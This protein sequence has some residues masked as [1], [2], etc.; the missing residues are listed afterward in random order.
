[1]TPTRREFLEGSASASAA[2]A[3]GGR[4]E[5]EGVRADLARYVGF[6]NKASGGAGDEATGGWLE[7]EL[8]RAGY[9]VER[10]P[11]EAPAFAIQ[12]ARI[13]C[14][15][16]AADVIPQ[17]IVVPTG[18]QGVSGP[19][20]HYRAGDPP[21]QPLDGAIAFVELP[22][23]RW[24]TSTAPAIRNA[25]REAA[26]LGARALVLVTNGPTGDALALNADPRASLAPIPIAI[27][28]PRDSAALV[29]A[30]ASGAAATLYLTG[31]V[32]HRPAF[33][34][35]GRLRR[36]SGRW[37]VISTPRSGWFTCAGERG[38]G[39]AAWLSLARWAPGALKHHSLMLLANS[40]HEYEYLGSE[41]AIAKMAPPPA[42]TAF[43][44][45]LGA[46]VAARDWHELGGGRLAPLPSADPQRFLVTS[47]PLLPTARGA[48]AGLPGLE[49]PY[50]A[51]KGGQGEA[52]SILAAG[53]ENVAGI[54]GN[55]RF[56]HSANDDARCLEDRL[57]PPV[58][59]ACRTLL[60]SIR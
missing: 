15:S 24:S 5:T 50:A 10:Q 37:I 23:A 47:D 39:V 31:T 58:I 56:H 51:S 35:I 8:R 3:M 30:S 43:W 6:G 7:D 25:A 53:Y 45:H 36:P 44:L 2:V 33:N 19:L 46:N 41:H 26:E 42:E 49:M 38:P 16:A 11:F 14:G 28:A 29:K 22:S 4:V 20:R 54:F 40:G 55:H 13:E 48:F 1:M 21:G 32:G 17:A 9:A 18:E 60:M 52:A 59:E 27:M 57:V 12:R 34:V